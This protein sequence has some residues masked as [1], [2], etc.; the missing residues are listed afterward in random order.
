MMSMMSMDTSSD[1]DGD[2]Q[3]RYAL[4]VTTIGWLVVELELERAA[5]T[6]DRFVEQVQAKRYVDTLVHR[7]VKKWF[8]QCGRYSVKGE[9]QQQQPSSQSGPPAT[10][11]RNSGNTI[12]TAPTRLLSSPTV[13][14]LDQQHTTSNKSNGSGEHDTNTSTAHEDADIQINDD[15]LSHYFNEAEPNGSNTQMADMLTQNEMNGLVFNSRGLVALGAYNQLII[16]LDSCDA[17]NGK[18]PIVGR[19]HPSTMRTLL[20]FEAQPVNHDNSPYEPILITGIHLL[21]DLESCEALAQTSTA[22]APQAMTNSVPST[23][24]LGSAEADQTPIKRPLDHFDS[25]PVLK[26]LKTKIMTG[27]IRTPS[28]PS[29]DTFN[30]SMLG[31][32]PMGLN[33]SMGMNRTMS[34]PV[35]NESVKPKWPTRLVIVRHGQSEQNAALD[36][37][38]DDIDTLASVRDADI[39]LTP[40]GEW[41]SQQTGRYLSTMEPFDIC[42]TSPYLRAINTADNIIKHLP[43][44]LK[45]YKDNWLREK[46]FGKWHGLTEKSIREKFPDE[47]VIRL[48]D[49]KYWY[50]FPGGENYLDVEMRIHCFLEKLSRDYAGR[51]VLVVTHQVPYKIFRGLFHHLDEQGLLALENVHNCGIQE[52]ILDTSKAPEGRMKLKHFNLKSYNMD[53]LPADIKAKC[54]GQQPHHTNDHPG[55]SSTTSTTTTTSTAALHQQHH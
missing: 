20:F 3:K 51:S 14:L 48:R 37:L 46:E 2:A 32:S 29:I 7:I 6:C 40:I 55:A 52:Y 27:L 45:V 28:R 38:Q 8:V 39:R 34:L 42:F 41:Q 1:G 16:T 31:G 12:T 30:T 21:K 18:Y 36:I 23:P 47:Y 11:V 25:T 10:P 26:R 9:Q 24:R 17:L 33:R 22:P 53:E 43:Y 54:S 35:F 44:R 15:K 49:G 19:V 5:L 50:R 13:S 4:L